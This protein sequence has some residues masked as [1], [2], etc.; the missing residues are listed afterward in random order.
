MG[1]AVSLQHQGCGSI[2]G[3]AQLQLGSDPWCA[4]PYAA[5]LPKKKRKKKLP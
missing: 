4:T 5:G 3:Q 1:L 2:P